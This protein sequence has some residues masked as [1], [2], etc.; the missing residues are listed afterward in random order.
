MAL[1]LHL[2]FKIAWEVWHG[3]LVCVINEDNLHAGWAECS[4]ATAETGHATVGTSQRTKNNKDNGDYGCGK[5]KCM[6]H[7]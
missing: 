6:K 4:E 7:S 1:N 2:N 5:G 3:V